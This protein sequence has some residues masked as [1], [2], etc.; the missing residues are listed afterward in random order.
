VTDDDRDIGEPQTAPPAS[1]PELDP[2]VK[3]DPVE[4]T[5][6]D[7]STQPQEDPA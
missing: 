6:D 3:N 2:D 5:K 7:G 4:P 1:D